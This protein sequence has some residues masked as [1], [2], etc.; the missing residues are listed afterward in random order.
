MGWRNR[1]ALHIV[2]DRD[3]VVTVFQQSMAKQSVFVPKLR[4]TIMLQAADIGPSRNALL[5][6]SAAMIDF[7]RQL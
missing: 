7:L 2:G 4:P 6:V 3:F 1:P 5:E